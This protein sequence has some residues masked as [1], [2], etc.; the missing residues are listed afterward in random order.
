MSLCSEIENINIAI[1]YHTFLKESF[2]KYI[3]YISNYRITTLEYVSKLSLFQEKFG[4]KLKEPT[5]KEGETKPTDF[6]KH[7]Y[8]I[9]SRIVKVIDKNIE[10]INLVNM[11]IESYIE[12]FNAIIVENTTLLEKFQSMFNDSKLELLNKYRD[13][14]K[15]RDSY[16]SSMESTEDILN[17]FYSGNKKE[18]SSDIMKASIAASKKKEKEYIKLNKHCKTFEETF[19]VS[20]QSSIENIKKLICELASQMKDMITEFFILSQNNTNMQLNE[21]NS[22]LTELS[23][24]EEEKTIGE[25]LDNSFKDNNKLFPSKPEKYKLKIFQ[26]NENSNDILISNP[27]L[28]LEDGFN[29]IT[30]LKDYQVFSVFKAMKENFE[31]V[32]DNNMDLKIEEEKINVVQLVNRILNLESDEKLNKN[33]LP[34][35]DDVKK[36]DSLLNIHHNR[37]VFLQKMSEFRNKGKFEIK[38][39]TFEIMSKLFTTIVN[40]IQRDKDFHSI[41]NAIILSQTYYIKDEKD[42]TGKRYIQKEIE[43][44]P[45]FKSK[46]F[47]EEFLDF[48]I[49][50][51]IITS[52]NNDAKS[53][54]ILKENQKD[55]ESKKGNIAFS[56]ILPYADNMYEFGLEK[57]V[58]FDLILPIMNKF[59][60]NEELIE[61][62]KNVINNK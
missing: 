46:Q 19:N 31:L 26:M 55:S 44:N 60:L 8:S 6:I 29:E 27:I 1:K 10:T 20:Y 28:R 22:H 16:I 18:V 32:E 57:K 3:K 49:N 45:I 25:I 48:C 17:K 39:K 50:K 41:K 54:N 35:K 4:S 34:T 47:W 38:Q 37:V 62:V 61:T 11:G 2:E 15:A 24:L 21:I 42:K 56:Q 52:Y 53:G 59:Q 40:T 5:I 43:N 13:I 36:L 30:I 9:L 33:L 7:I 14:D 23:K 58:I 12:T 51:E